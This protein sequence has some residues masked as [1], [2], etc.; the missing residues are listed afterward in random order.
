MLNI[1]VFCIM[2]MKKMMIN[3]LTIK[4]FSRISS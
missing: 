2:D 1:V 3:Y 4:L